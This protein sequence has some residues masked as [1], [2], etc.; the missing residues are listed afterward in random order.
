MMRLVLIWGFV[1]L[2]GALWL[3]RRTNEKRARGR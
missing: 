1:V 2:A 3:S